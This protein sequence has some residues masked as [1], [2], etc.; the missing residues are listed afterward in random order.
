M[1]FF[2]FRCLTITLLLYRNIYICIRKQTIFVSIYI[3][4]TN[5]R[6]ILFFLI[7]RLYIC[8][9]TVFH[10]F[11]FI[12]LFLFLIYWNIIIINRI[13]YYYQITNNKQRVSFFF[14]FLSNFVAFITF[15]LFLPS[16]QLNQSPSC[17]I[18]L[19]SLI[20]QLVQQQ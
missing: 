18:K 7:S 4:L 3:N 9:N 6:M 13:V 16:K 12:F 15:Q 1:Y 20:L 10:L 14:F 11:N 8:D 2:F 5:I 17:P 19:P